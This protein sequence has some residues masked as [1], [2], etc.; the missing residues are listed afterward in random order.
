MDDPH[1]QPTASEPRDSQVVGAQ[2][3]PDSRLD[4]I[5]AVVPQA[6]SS[7]THIIF[8]GVLGVYLV[9]LPL[10]GVNVSARAELIGGNY[11]NV[12]SD[13]GACIAAGLTVHLVRRERTRTQ[14]MRDLFSHMHR[15]HDE[16]SAQLAALTVAAG[17]NAGA[18]PG[19]P[20]GGVA[21][22]A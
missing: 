13:L 14:E 6:L 2:V 10:L 11:T 4:R 3:A 16:M 18:D 21:P 8:L 15:R 1:T 17:R 7:H 9:I 5:L 19:A 12:T 22:G 20:G